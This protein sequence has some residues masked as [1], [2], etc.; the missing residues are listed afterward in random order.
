MALEIVTVPCRTDNYAYLLRDIA[1]GTVALVDAPEAAPIRAAL[2]ARGWTLDMIL[3][4]HHHDDHV[5]GVE[6][7]RSAF[8]PE[9]VGAEA[10]RYRLPRLDRAVV[11]GDTVAVGEALGNVMEVPGHTIGHIAYFF[12]D[13]PALFS[14]DSL[15]VMGCGRLFEGSP[16]QMWDSLGRMAALP[17]ET[18]VYSGHEYAEANMAFARALDP[19]HAP[20]RDRAAEIARVRARGEPTVPARLD[21]ERRTNPFLRAVDPALKA[22]L[23]MPSSSDAQVFAAIRRRKDSF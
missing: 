18:L 20:T 8:D 9:V 10:D 1:T 4:T 14:A 16:E 2:A 6:D 19:G 5:A 11:G 13:G 17:G 12:P 22:E 3:I 21:L 15:M 7:L 23:G